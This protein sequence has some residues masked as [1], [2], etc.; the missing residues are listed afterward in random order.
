MNVD[1]HRHPTEIEPYQLAV[2][3]AALARLR[4]RLGRG[5]ATG[6]ALDASLAYGAPFDVVS[7]LGD[8]WLEE[9][10][11][12]SQ[13]GFDLPLF[14]TW[15]DQEKWCF[16]HARSPETFAVPLLLLH[17]YSG[18]LAE[19]AQVGV[20]LASPRTYAASA[21]D[22]FHVV[23]PALPGFGLSDP[24]PNAHA[25]AEGCAALMQRLGY[26]RYVVHGSD[27]GANLALTLA[28]VDGEHV[29]GLHV[30]ALPSY[31]TEALD[32]V[33]SLTRHE[34]S[35]LALLTELR[36]ELSFQLP[37]SPLEQLAFALA[38]LEHG[39]NTAKSADWRAPLLAGLTLSW[40]L[41]SAHVRNDL[42]RE[43][44]LAAPPATKT[45]VS[46]HSFPLDAPSL[47]RFAEMRHRVVDWTEHAHGGSMPALEQPAL[48]VRSLRDFFRRLR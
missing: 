14:T 16:A 28:A 7:E 39:A 6:E 22:A 21:S 15:F 46:V 10:D 33:A 32:E 35:Q 38:R 31:P 20:Q 42:Y 47:R 1:V 37:E 45:P 34:K 36:D 43:H 2:P 19:V 13:A 4:L 24:A 25:I 11:L 44:R 48:L 18:S 8:Y 26:S 41:G 29:A 27:L 23:C 12:E 40:A 5:A 17:G 9:F 30:T 3:E